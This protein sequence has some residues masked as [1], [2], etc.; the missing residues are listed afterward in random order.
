M[1]NPSQASPHVYLLL[2]DPDR[3]QSML[4]AR[5]EDGAVFERFRGKPLHGTWTPPLK[6]EIRRKSERGTVLSESDFPCHFW[7]GVIVFSERAVTALHDLLEGWGELLPLTCSDGTYFAFNVTRVVEALDTEHSTLKLFSTGR[8]MRV[9]RYEFFPDR[10]RDEVIFKEPRLHLI[11]AYV[12]SPFAERIATAG[13]LGFQ[14]RHVWP[15][16]QPT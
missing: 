11:D 14:L 5:P 1:V 8:I 12:T 3:Y 4:P 10:V 13:L 6:V 9:E 15:A 16:D 7:P 2:P